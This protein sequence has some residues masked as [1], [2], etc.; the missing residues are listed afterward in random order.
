MN[1]LGLNKISSKQ[2]GDRNM[3]R[4]IISLNNHKYIENRKQHF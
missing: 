4:V 3:D 2:K 1:G